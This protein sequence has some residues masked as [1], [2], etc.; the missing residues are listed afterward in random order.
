MFVLGVAGSKTNTAEQGHTSAGNK[1]LVKC[2]LPALRAGEAKKTF[3]DF[4]QRYLEKNV[5][6][7]EKILFLSR[8]WLM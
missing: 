3:E 8:Q 2:L 4:K 1:R 5:T 6:R 7:L